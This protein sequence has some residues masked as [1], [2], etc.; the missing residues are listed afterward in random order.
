MIGLGKGGSL[1]IYPFLGIY[2]RFLGS[3]SSIPP[4]E[5]WTFVSK[6]P[7]FVAFFWWIFEKSLGNL[8][9]GK[10]KNSA[11]TSNSNLKIRRT[12]RD[13]FGIFLCP[14]HLGKKWMSED[15]DIWGK[16]NR[17]V[18]QEWSCAPSKNTNGLGLENPAPGKGDFLEDGPPI[19]VINGVF[20]PYG[21]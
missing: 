19:P 15:Q 7:A 18:P 2:V 17:K 21:N 9:L 10:Q 16:K 5:P 8:K 11:A 6:K 1:Y 13:S 20:S 4:F 12:R 14:S 3:M